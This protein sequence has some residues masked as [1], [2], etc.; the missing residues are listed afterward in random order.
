ME[1]EVVWDV[2]KRVVL[3]ILLLGCTA[4]VQSSAFADNS[5][6][7]AWS[8]SPDPSATGY[9]VYYGATSGNYTN[10][11]DVGNST[12]AIIP[13]LTAGAT[14][15]F[16]VVAYDAS[17][18]ESLPSNEVSYTVPGGSSG[19]LAPTLNPLGNL[20]IN[21]N[22]ALQTVNLTGITSGSI[23]ENSTQVVSIVASSS[24]PGLIPNPT[25]TYSSP[26]ATG[27]LTFTPEPN[28]YGV[29][30]ITV[31]VNDD[32][33][34]NNAITRTFVVTVNNLNYP[35]TLDPLNNLTM[36]EDAGLQ[37]VNLSG[38][39]SG[40]DS[41]IQAL[42]VTASSSNTG[43]IPTPTVIYIS[44]DVT[45]WL[46][47]APNTN[48]FGTAT[49]TVTVNDGQPNSNTISRTFTVTVNPVLDSPTL[50]PL[51]NL[52][53]SE[54]S[55]QQTVN[56][57]GIS[58]GA[59]N[60]NQT[61]SVTAVSSAPGLI[62]NPT[63]AYSSP[64]S[65]GTLKFTPVSDSIGTAII[66]V[67]VTDSGASNNVTSASFTVTVNPVNHPPTLDPLGNITIN[68]DAGA[69]TVN[70]SGIS[71]GRS[72]EVQ[73]LTISATSSSTSLIPNPTVTY[74]SPNATGTLTFTPVANATG[75][76]TITVT[77]NDGQP[78]NN[79][80]TQTFTVTVNPVNDT[81]TINS[82]NNLTI[83][84]GAGQQTVNLSGITSGAANE[85]QTLTVTAASS[86]T[87][88]IP[89]P[90]VTYSSP[91]TTGSLKFTPVTN[92]TGTA[93]ITV[94]V[95]D[96]GTSNNVTAT[97]FT[98]TV[99]PINKPPKL[100]PL[101]NLTINE[102]AGPQIVNFSGVSS[103]STNP[104][105]TLT[106]TATSSS[107]G[108]IPNPT[109]SYSSPDTAGSLML[110]PVAN[111]Y[112]TTTIIVTVNDGQSSFSRAFSV[113]VNPVND[114]PTLDPLSNMTVNSSMGQQTV[115]LTGISS[116]AAN[117]AQT[118]TITTATSD[119][120]LIPLPTP[121]YVSPAT[122]GLLQ[123]TPMLNASGTVTL[124]AAVRDGGLS[125]SVIYR[126]FVVTLLPGPTITTITNQVIKTNTSA[127]PLSFNIGHATIPAS[128]LILSAESSNPSLIPVSNIVFG[129]SDANR[130]VTL[131]PLT[132]QNGVSTVT[133]VVSDGTM[134]ASTTFQLSVQLPPAG[135]ANLIIVTVNGAG[136]VTPNLNGQQLALG[137][138]YS[139]TAVPAAGQVFNGWS[140][141]VS[142]VSPTLTFIAQSNMIV[143]A[144]FVPN[145]FTPVAGTYNGLFYENDAV[146]LNSAG[147]FK[148]SVTSKGT[149]TGTLTLGASRY[150]IKG[151]FNS[152]YQATNL[153]LR[154]IGTPLSLSLRV[155]TGGEMDR[156][157]GTLSDGTWT[158]NLLGDRA[159]FNAKTN[160]A[161]L[162]GSYTIIIPGEDG[163]PSIPAG[164][165]WGTVKVATSG[166]ITFAGSLAD[167][168]KVTQSSA[169]SKLGAWPFYVP[170]SKGA[171]SVMS[172]LAFENRSTDDI[173]GNMNWIKPAN[174]LSLKYP[175]GFTYQTEALG[176]AYAP[177]PLG[178]NMLGLTTASVSF[179]GGNVGADFIN[180]VTLGLASK[181]VNN[182]SNALSM[183]F[184]LTSGAFKGTVTNPTN[185][186][187]LPFSGVVLPKMNAGYGYALGT[188]QTSAVTFGP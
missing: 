104:F 119:P 147:S 122:T 143:Q 10:S 116:G 100:N 151:Q 28:S 144:N 75:T 93:T 18:L 125:N 55:G 108:L 7:L 78:A 145:P 152:L 74:S 99:I 46:W 62:P 129:G 174:P 120:T 32:Q 84:E 96:N 97:S 123:F 110:A 22:A 33:P 130:T 76:A 79:T 25:V 52:T 117:E 50:N 139:M 137:K 105:P 128:S 21:E 12:T 88:L 186:R 39:T 157:F 170:L 41:D 109:V 183:T 29:A 4:L 89:N 158:A 9:K 107:Q 44:P 23:S 30:T 160:L 154:S 187:S 140:G 118:L 72:N 155:G 138:S 24:N 35:P 90:T 51:S 5:V 19:N 43:L 31:I 106:V 181:V 69:Q 57:S 86:V 81:P 77:V 102:D 56:L 92:V 135:P 133:I 59:A 179:S 98:V 131:T 185:K 156:I 94:T 64:N 172:W 166:L 2:W 15:Y 6:N 182:S 49:I 14:Y 114:T 149:Y 163:T 80:V 63:V 20:S 173:H 11:L 65:S 45:G 161:P 8:A 91:S 71:P 70:L 53:I 85:S 54:N 127:G 126:S 36:D 1:R 124:T 164:H 188:N 101:T 47:F 153:I 115:N 82:L 26:D 165:G 60:E 121:V 167:G 175:A 184:T 136:S 67:T 42:T 177:P 27:T 103:G 61:L 150:S 141:K 40:A 168:T 68:E 159:V 146:R 73:T 148:V 58:S 180:Y 162:A 48:A 3:V 17:G 87:G 83:N 13:G 132:D 38:I 95:R 176:S 171:G 134:T 169:I 34:A 178:V 142:S 16:V 37:I 66:T 112:G 111:A 113:T